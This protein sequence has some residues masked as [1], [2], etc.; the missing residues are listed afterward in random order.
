[1]LYTVYQVNNG[2]NKCNNNGCIFLEL[3]Q[4]YIKK[5]TPIIVT[6]VGPIIHLINDARSRIL[7]TVYQCLYT[8]LLYKKTIEVEFVLHVK[9][10]PL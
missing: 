4:I 2:T 6:S 10:K 1:M 9:H 3:H 5:Y 7:E 8:Q